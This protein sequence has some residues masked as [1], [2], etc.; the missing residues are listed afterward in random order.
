MISLCLLY[1]LLTIPD[2]QFVYNFATEP[3]SCVRSG[4]QWQESIPATGQYLIVL[5]SRHSREGRER[6]SGLVLAMGCKNSVIIEEVAGEVSEEDAKAL[7]EQFYEGS[8][9]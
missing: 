5:Y 7:V 9:Q 6:L 2:L 3:F 4:V 1:E 8:I